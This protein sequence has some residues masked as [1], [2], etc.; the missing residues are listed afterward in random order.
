MKKISSSFK[1]TAKE[2]LII[3]CGVLASVFSGFLAFYT[4]KYY[5]PTVIVLLLLVVVF[6]FYLFKEPMVG[7][8]SLISFMFF[9]GI[10]GREGG[11]F[12]EVIP[13]GTLI[14]V[15]LILTLL[16]IWYNVKKYDLRDLK[17]ELCYF[18]LLWF[19]LSVAEVINPAGASI[20]G[21]LQEIRSAAFQPLTITIIGLLLINTKKKAIN[22]VKLMIISSV[23][24]SL[25]GM[26]QHF[27][28]LTVGEQEFLDSGAAVTHMLFGKLR[29]FSFYTDAGQFG[30]SQAQFAIL[31]IIFALGQPKI[32]KK[33]LYGIYAGLSTFGMLISGTWGALF[34]FLAGAFIAVL[35]TQ[36]TKLILVGL[37]SVI[38]LISF[39]KFTN[40][41][42]GNYNIMRMRS[43]LNTE[44]ASLNV[45]FNT[46]KVLKDYM[47][48]YPF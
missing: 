24:A 27:F 48:S 35:A 44:D 18:S 4:Q 5:A 26:R 23:V 45:R 36:K 6:L 46:Q 33:I 39:L 47:K 2:Y 11:V 13:L 32:S 14:E 16:S 38:L 1:L 21:W 9:R 19:L 25:Y 40:I 17:N 43:A 7:L 3:F 22:V 34:A 8:Y 41:G 10:I 30:A 20:M 42:N 15:L 31:C 29:V 37:L 12:S 28:G